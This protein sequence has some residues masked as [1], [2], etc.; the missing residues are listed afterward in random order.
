MVSPSARRDGVRYLVGLGR[1]SERR[2]CRLVGITRASS[3]YV[4][5]KA[6]DR[7]AF[8]SAVVAEANRHS[9]YGYRRVT[10]MLKQQGWMVNH[11]RVHRLWQR[12]GLQIPKRVK[13]K[14]RVGP[15]KPVLQRSTHVN[16]VWTYD[17]MTIRTERNGSLRV[18]NILDE[19]SRECLASVVA[20]SMPAR[21]VLDVLDWLFLTRGTPEHLRS[22]NGPEFIAHKV[23]DWLNEHKCQTIYI[24]PGSPWENPF[25]ESFNGHFRTECL[26][27]YA[28]T[29]GSEAQTI[30]DEW[31][32]E[33][34]H[35]RPHSSL[36]YRTPA[37]FAAR[38]A[39]AQQPT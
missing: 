9:R 34:N 38:W 18:L 24:T 36:G 25:I 5:R 37:D 23:Q 39:A 17:F 6:P 27:R 8:Q 13:H 28:F 1:Y 7:E 33:Y 22:D 4:E 20:R 2:A 21:R 10:I 12:L 11:K 32:T 19:Y 26:D 14:R 29:N 35:H 31:R 3:R 15:T 30:I 16:H